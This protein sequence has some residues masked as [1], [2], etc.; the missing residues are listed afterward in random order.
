MSNNA[1]LKTTHII[2][3]Q[4]RKKKQNKTKQKVYANRSIIISL[5]KNATILQYRIICEDDR[6]VYVCICIY[7]SRSALMEKSVIVC[8]TQ[9]RVTVHCAVFF[10]QVSK[11]KK[12]KN[13][14][15]NGRGLGYIHLSANPPVN[16]WIR[17]AR[18][19]YNE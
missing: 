17:K 9:M 10:P 18:K 6:F 7:I 13:S 1:K 12:K 5:L 11:R 3:H 4:N 8:L 19:R 16:R 15:K 2:K 14:Y